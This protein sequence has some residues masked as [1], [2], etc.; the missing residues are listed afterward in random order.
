MKPK[1]WCFSYLKQAFSRGQGL[2][3]MTHFG[4]KYIQSIDKEM[5]LL[6]TLIVDELINK[7]KNLRL[8]FFEFYWIGYLFGIECWHS[9][10]LKMKNTQLKLDWRLIGLKIYWPNGWIRC[11]NGYETQRIGSKAFGLIWVL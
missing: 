1:M 11:P 2:K 9:W 5:L 6:E 4:S 3:N 8:V 7:L 10:C